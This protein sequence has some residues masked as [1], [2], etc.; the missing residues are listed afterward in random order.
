MLERIIKYWNMSSRKLANYFS[1][2]VIDFIVRV[3]IRSQQNWT[4]STEFSWITFPYTPSL[5][6][7]NILHQSSTFISTDKPTMTHHYHPGSTVYIRDHSVYHISLHLNY[8]IFTKGST[9]E[10]NWNV[11]EHTAFKKPNMFLTY[12]FITS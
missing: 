5:P 9:V 8:V 4:E 3:A 11:V 1:I 10:G 12:L 7:I 6:S 2:P